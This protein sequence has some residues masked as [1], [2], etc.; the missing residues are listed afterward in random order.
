MP[1]IFEIILLIITGFIAGI[2][3]VMAGG[4]SMLTFPLLIFLGLPPNVANGTNRVAILI[5]NIFSNAGFKS[6]GVST[7]PFSIYL[8]TSALIG[9]LIG[10][11]LAIDIKGEV[12]NKIL[13]VILI[14]TVTTL[15]FKPKYNL[16]TIQDR[17]VGKHLVLSTIVFFFIGMY[18]GFIQV[19][20]GFIIL[21]AL[22]QINN[23][24]L[25]RSNAVKVFVV[26][27]YTI[28]S[29]AIFAYNDKINWNY[30]LILAIGNGI[31][32]WF[33][34]RW[35]VEKGEKLIKTILVIAVIAISLK[36]WFYQ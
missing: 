20:V 8:A 11:Q 19:G 29:V 30:G 9:S 35:S 36:L 25:I 5:Q 15:V 23:L 34:S 3:N 12:F 28:A 33:G 2:A 16:S 22:S 4:G 26:F 10:A 21:W 13:A 14:I 32:G 31:G 17:I 24:D 27:I 18:G 1:S 6:K 7:F